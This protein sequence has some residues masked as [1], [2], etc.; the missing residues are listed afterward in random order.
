MLYEFC[1]FLCHLFGYPLL[2]DKPWTCSHCSPH[3]HAYALFVF[4]F[5]PF[6]TGQAS[7]LPAM[8]GPCIRLDDIGSLQLLSFNVWD[9]KEP[10][11]WELPKR[12]WDDGIDSS[13]Q[14]HG[15]WSTRHFW[16]PF[17]VCTKKGYTHPKKM[18]ILISNGENE[19]EPW[20]SPCSALFSTSK[21]CHQGARFSSK[22]E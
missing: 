5:G 22:E 8:S 10:S 20:D 18:A 1:V 4:V 15:N 16:E 21:L 7:F 9:P 17:W 19:D 13:N 2:R 11:F 3:L 6:W 14:Y 12:S